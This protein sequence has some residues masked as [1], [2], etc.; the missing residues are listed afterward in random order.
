MLFGG[1][2][3]FYAVLRGPGKCWM[4]TT[5]F[6]RFAD[7]VIAAAGGSRGETKRGSSLSGMLGN[8]IGGD[9]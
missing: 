9:R 8:I 3:L 5:P 6:S 4:Q 1:E 7:R 2:G